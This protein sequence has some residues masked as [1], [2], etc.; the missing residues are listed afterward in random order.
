LNRFG[1][2]ILFDTNHQASVR[3]AKARSAVPTRSFTEADQQIAATVGEHK[4]KEKRST[5]DLE[6]P[7]AGISELPETLWWA[8]RYAPLPT[9]RLLDRSKMTLMRHWRF[10]IAAVQPDPEP[11]F[12]SRKS[13]L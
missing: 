4:R 6:P 1:H 12:A 2:A 11:Y 3:W 5:F 8:R 13:L 7:I 10:K 9:L